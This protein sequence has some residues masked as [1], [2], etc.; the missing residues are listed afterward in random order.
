[1]NIKLAQTKSSQVLIHTLFG[2][3]FRDSDLVPRESRELNFTL[4]QSRLQTRD[5]SICSR[6]PNHWTK[7]SHGY[8]FTYRETYI[9][10]DL[11]SFTFIDRNIKWISYCLCLFYVNFA[12]EL[13]RLNLNK[14][15]Y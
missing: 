1:M 11:Q 5:L 6:T 3:S 15:Y 12:K 4:D 13:I 10:T 8:V 9:Y 2:W 14:F 7:A